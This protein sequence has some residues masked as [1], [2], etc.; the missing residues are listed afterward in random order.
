MKKIFLLLPVLDRLK[1]LLNISD[2]SSSTEYLIQKAE[3]FRQF[4]KDDIE[5]VFPTECISFKNY[6]QNLKKEIELY[7][8]SLT[9]SL[10]PSTNKIL[11]RLLAKTC[12]N[13]DVC[14]C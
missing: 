9:S 12:Y 14:F 8:I 2:N 13:T 6:I 4:Y 5:D 10:I 3:N 7:D 1:R 11:L